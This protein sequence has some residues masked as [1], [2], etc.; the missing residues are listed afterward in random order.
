MI[1]QSQGQYLPMAGLKLGQ[2]QASSRINHPVQGIPRNDPIPSA[3]FTHFWDVVG[4]T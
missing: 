4:C 2:S 3:K 1:T